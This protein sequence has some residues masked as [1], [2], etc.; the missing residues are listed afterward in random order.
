MSNTSRTLRRGVYKEISRD[1][2]VI[3]RRLREASAET[4]VELALA[5]SVKTN[6]IEY[7]T[8]SWADGDRLCTAIFLARFPTSEL[9]C[10]FLSGSRRKADRMCKILKEYSLSFSETGCGN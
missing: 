10:F 7:V 3:A 9:V 1:P 4:E 8:K 6:Q 5:R 2:D